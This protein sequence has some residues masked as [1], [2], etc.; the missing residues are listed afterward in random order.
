M[1]ISASSSWKWW[2]YHYQNETPQLSPI[3]ARI[4][5]KL[6]SRHGVGVLIPAILSHL[7]LKS[8]SR[9]Q[10][11]LSDF[12]IIVWTFD[13]VRAKTIYFWGSRCGLSM[14]Q[15]QISVMIAEQL[16]RAWVFSSSHFKGIGLKTTQENRGYLLNTID[17]IF[18]TEKD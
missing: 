7:L 4:L 17:E 3:H 8:L 9:T 12:E 5:W 6:F 11:F 1:P 2:Y 14:E 16:V 10:K 13:V 15:L 18:C